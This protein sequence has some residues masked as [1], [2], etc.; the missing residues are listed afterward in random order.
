MPPGGERLE[1]GHDPPVVAVGEAGG[2]GVFLPDLD[3]WRGRPR[4]PVGGDDLPSV[5]HAPV[6]DELAELGQIARAKPESGRSQRHPIGIRLPVVVQDPERAKQPLDRML[7]EGPPG[8]RLDRVTQQ[9]RVR[10][11]V[12][13][14]FARS[15]VER[16]REEIAILVARPAHEEIDREVVIVQLQ[17]RAHG[18]EMVQ[19]DLFRLRPAA[20]RRIRQHRAERFVQVREDP[21]VV[22]DPEHERGHRLGDGLRVMDPESVVEFA[23]VT[24]RDEPAVADY[25]QGQG[26]VELALREETAIDGLHRISAQPDVLRGRHRPPIVQLHRQRIVWTLQRGFGDAADQKRSKGKDEQ[27]RAEHDQR[28]P[29]VH[30][31][32]RACSRTTARR[33]FGVVRNDASNTS[34]AGRLLADR[35]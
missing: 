11:P 34:R 2:H 30:S 7:F 4:D 22:K 21:V 18:Q 9:L 10:I 17:P 3:L 8:A 26:V 27:Q 33:G 24:L 23:G 16:A 5:P 13:E 31:N 20:E 14:S 32:P 25:E 19:R 29:K 12:A 15:H 6:E 28:P 35:V 1:L